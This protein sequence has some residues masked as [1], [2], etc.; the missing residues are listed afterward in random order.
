M[1]HGVV[2]REAE[3][4]GVGVMLPEFKPG[5]HTHCVTLDKTF[6][7]L[8]SGDDNSVTGLLNTAGPGEQCLA[9]S[10]RSVSG[11]PGLAGAAL[12]V[13]GPGQGTQCELD[14]F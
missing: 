12:P 3:G 1:A 10:G 9:H 2:L 8:H 7:Q 5:P 6:P 14:G 11:S 4:G 13:S